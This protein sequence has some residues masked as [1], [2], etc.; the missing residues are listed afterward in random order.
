MAGLPAR[1]EPGELPGFG[2]AASTAGAAASPAAAA[3]HATQVQQRQQLQPQVQQHPS[4]SPQPSRRCSSSA[5]PQFRTGQ[6]TPQFQPQVQQQPHPQQFAPQVQQQPQPQFEQ[7]RQ[8][9]VQQHASRRCYRPTLRP[10]VAGSA[11]PGRHGPSATGQS[12]VGGPPVRDHTPR[13][14]AY[15]GHRYAPFRAGPYRW[16]G[17]MQ[18]Q[19]YGVGAY[20]PLSLIVGA[21]ADR[22]LVGLWPGR[23]R[24]RATSGCVTGPMC[25]WS[26]RIPARSSTAPIPRS[27][28]AMRRRPRTMVRPP[29]RMR[30]RPAMRRQCLRRGGRKPLGNFANWVAAAYQENGQPVCY[31][32]TQ[33][34]ASTPPVPNRA[35]P[36]LTV[37][38]RATGRDAVSIGGILADAA[39]AGITLQVDRAGLELLSRRRQPPLPATAPRR[40]RPFRRQPG[41]GATHVAV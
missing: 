5:Q 7:Q 2:T 41:D 32:S 17:G 4:R 23:I 28:R 16:P 21:Y 36:V 20:L 22:R 11:G 29:R 19:H 10:G 37:T 40:W 27:P 1:F 33:A 3:T 26:I 14:F 15:H 6:P 13:R 8:P 30:L 39:N 12:H 25:C 34:V 24:R 18:Y 9:P 38:E 31:A 35:P